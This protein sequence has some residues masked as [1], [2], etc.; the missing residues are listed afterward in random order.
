MDLVENKIKTIVESLSVGP[1]GASCSAVKLEYKNK[2]FSHMSCDTKNNFHLTSK[3]LFDLASL[4]KVIATTTLVMMAV[5]EKKIN[6]DDSIAKYLGFFDEIKIKNLLSHTSG[7]Q[8]WFPFYLVNELDVKKVAMGL[9]KERDVG[10]ERIYSDVGFILLGEILK[11]IYQD[12]F[13]KIFTTK[14][15]SKLKDKNIFFAPQKATQCVPTSLGNPFEQNL[16]KK[17]AGN[18]DCLVD[19]F[20]WRTYRLQ[21]EVND[22][23]SWHRFQGVSSHAGLF[24]T[25]DAVSSFLKQLLNGE[26]VSKNTL[27]LFLKTKICNNSLGFANHP[28]Q[29][30]I[31]APFE[32]FGHHGFT[33]CTLLINPEHSFHLIYLSNRQYR[34]LNEQILYPDWKDELTQICQIYCS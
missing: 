19:D 17:Y 15:V 31:T 12:D 5:D 27:N 33:G 32:L 3:S 30:R 21:G 7:L 34:G 13:Q 6:I 16:A 23:N 14:I 9:D 25:L 26:I 22:G 20:F 10:V 11:T 1:L 18:V 4:T 28:D 8:A 24:G 29:L 2:S